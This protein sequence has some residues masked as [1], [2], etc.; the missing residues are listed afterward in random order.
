[1]SISEVFKNGDKVQVFVGSLQVEGTIQLV[2]VTRVNEGN[3]INPAIK[4]ALKGMK[5]PTV[6]NWNQLAHA[7]G[8]QLATK[9]MAKGAR[10]ALLQDVAT[11]LLFAS[12]EDQSLMSV[13]SELSERPKNELL[14]FEPGEFRIA[15]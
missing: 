6:L 13:A 15:E 8:N 14:F 2:E 5:I 11:A 12:M 10:A 4:R 3:G 9:I 1:M 7:I